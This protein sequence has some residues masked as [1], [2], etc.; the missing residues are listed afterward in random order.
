MDQSAS[1][2]CQAGHALLL[3]CRSGDTDAIPFDT[4][5][6]GLRLLVIDTRARHELTGGEY[7]SRR[8]ECE[9]ASRLLGVPSLRYVTDAGDGLGTLEDPVL[10]RRARHVITDNQRVLEVVGLLRAGSIGKIGPL[11]TES[12]ASL[13]DDFEISWPE[14]DAA[15]DA[16]NAAGAL[17]ARMVGGGFGGSVIAL[18]PAARGVAVRDTV[19]EAYA[20][21]GWAEPGFLDAV[22]SGSARRLR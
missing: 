15:V 14:A 16:A 21:R 5:A 2:L 6:A 4:A 18:V 13:R 19:R 22:P 10:R 9:E 7:A 3:D 11:L 17:G 20:G 8:D 1:L 12:H